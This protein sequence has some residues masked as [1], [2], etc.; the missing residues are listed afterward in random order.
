LEQRVKL[1]LKEGDL[2]AVGVEQAKLTAEKF[3]T[4]P[5]TAIHCSSLRRAA[6]TA[7]IIAQ[8]FPALSP[9]RSQLLWECYPNVPPSLADYF[10]SEPAEVMA[11]QQEQ[12]ERAFEKY[13]R[14]TRGTDKYEIVVCHGNILRYFVCRAMEVS[15]EAWVRMDIC[16]CGVSEVTVK[17]DGSLVLVAHNDV[18]HLPFSLTTCLGG[19]QH[20]P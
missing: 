4:F 18:G 2:T 9:Q 10:A 20:V 8:E 6:E 7:G 19:K 13:F 16:N 14:P 3:R 12:A 15:P 5:I 1:G 11:R 17:S